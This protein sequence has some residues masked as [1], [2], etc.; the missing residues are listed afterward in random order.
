MCDKLPET[1][2]LFGIDLQQRYSLCYCWDLDRQL[3]IQKGGSFLTYTRNKEEHHNFTIVKSMLKIPPRHNGTIP[4][5]IKGQ[6]LRDHVAYFISNKQTKNGLD[7]NI[8]VIDVIYNIKSNHTSYYCCRLQKQTCHL[9]QR[10]V[11]RSFGA[12]NQL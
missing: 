9:Q 12:A 4:I 11:H 10:T 5:Q 3:F 7:P 2:F 1:D 6:D 8:H